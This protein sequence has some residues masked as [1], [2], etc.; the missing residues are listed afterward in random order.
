MPPSNRSTLL[1]GNCGALKIVATSREALGMAG[2]ADLRG[3]LAVAARD[4]RPR[5]D[6]PVRGGPPLRRSRAP[7]AARL[8]GGR[9]QRARRSPRSAGG[10][11]ASRSRSSWPPRAC[12]SLSVDEIRARLDDRFRLLDRRQPRDAA[13][14]D[15]ARDDAMEPRPSDGAG[16]AAVPP[17]CGVRRRLHAGR[18]DAT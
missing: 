15:A 9:A 13:S 2:R 4:D 3:A 7:R 8:R 11:T 17:A 18:R 5:R 1:L 12:R 6:A 10:S 16:T 14:S